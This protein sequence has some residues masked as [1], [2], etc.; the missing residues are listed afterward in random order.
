MKLKALVHEAKEG[1]YWAEAPAIPGSASQGE[2][3]EEL[4]RNLQEVVE[5]CLYED[6]PG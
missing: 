1:G 4:L 5:G 3:I 6:A 2:S